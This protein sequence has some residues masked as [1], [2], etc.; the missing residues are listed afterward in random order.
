[1]TTADDG[2]RA[3]KGGRAARV[4]AVVDDDRD[5]REIVSMVLEMEGYCVI[6]AANG[7]EAITLLQSRNDVRLIL[8]DLMMPEMNG[9]Q[10][11]SAQQNDPSIA[12]IPVVVLS[13]GEPFA[14]KAE[15]VHAAGFLMKPIDLELLL[16]T[17]RIYC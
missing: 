14:T 4:V 7:R 3:A 2:P 15:A 9:W 10:F 12:G 8:L 17:F 16:R 1:M 11:S 13:G 6:T 5:I